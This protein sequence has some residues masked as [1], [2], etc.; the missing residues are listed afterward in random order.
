MFSHYTQLKRNVCMVVNYYKVRVNSG[1]MN[2][3]EAQLKREPK[4]NME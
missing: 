2:E 1:K 3:I 4:M